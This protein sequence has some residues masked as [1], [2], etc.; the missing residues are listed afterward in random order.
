MTVSWTPGTDANAAM[1]VS[2]VYNT[3]PGS[4]LNTQIFCDFHDVDPVT[5]F[6]T[7]TVQAYLMAALES[8]NVPFV[9]LAQR[10]RT[11]LLTADFNLGYLNIIS[12]FEVPTPVS[13]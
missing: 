3:P 12:T 2:L 7:G 10:V 5:G 9:V 8:S 4:G 1:Y 11:S 6:G 13:P